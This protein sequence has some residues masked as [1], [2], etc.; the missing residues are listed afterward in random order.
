MSSDS[1]APAVLLLFVFAVVGDTCHG[2]STSVQQQPVAYGAPQAQ[3]PAAWNERSDCSPGS[4]PNSLAD[5]VDPLMAHCDRAKAVAKVAVLAVLAVA[6]EL[7]ESA[8]VADGAAVET[9]GA[10]DAAGDASTAA[11]VAADSVARAD[12]ASPAQRSYRVSSND[13][14]NYVSEPTT[15]SGDTHDVEH[16]GN[17]SFKVTPR[18]SNQALPVTVRLIAPSSYEVIDSNG[19][20]SVVSTQELENWYLRGTPG[21]RVIQIQPQ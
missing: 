13:N 18:N 10:A 3:Q 1:W 16:L 6:S 17:G 14:G 19:T 21:D 7:G 15:G 12:E 2:P 8:A 4:S 20:R 9:A 11:G 5:A